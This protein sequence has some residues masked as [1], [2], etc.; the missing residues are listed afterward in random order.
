[1]NKGKA[2]IGYGTSQEHQL[3]IVDFVQANFADNRLVSVTEL[4]DGTF[5]M[6]IENPPSSGRAIHQSIR[7]GKESFAAILFT[8]HLY[9]AGKGMR[10]EQ[11]LESVV[12]KEEI[13][14]SY[15]SGINP[16]FMP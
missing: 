6:T 9:L 1:M 10:I 8:A 2:I 11:I 3:E 5:T 16:T 4:E 12:V 15:S 14:Y 7:L 13:Q